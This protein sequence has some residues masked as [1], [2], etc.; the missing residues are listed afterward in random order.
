MH[1]HSLFLHHVQHI[2]IHNVLASSF[3]IKV[4]TL[5]EPFSLDES[6]MDDITL[7]SYFQ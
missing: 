7:G 4:C 3:F 2:T 1:D 6:L 5:S